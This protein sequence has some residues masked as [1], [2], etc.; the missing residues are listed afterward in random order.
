MAAN[1]RFLSC[2]SRM[3]GLFQTSARFVRRD[4]VYS[5]S[6]NESCS[7]RPSFRAKVLHGERLPRI[8]C[9]QGLGIKS[10]YMGRAAIGKD[11]DHPLGL[12]R[13]GRL[14]HQRQARAQ[15]AGARRGAGRRGGASPWSRCSTRSRSSSPAS[16]WSTWP[17]SGP[18]R[19]G[20]RCRRGRRTCARAARRG[21][22]TT[23][24]P[25]AHT[26]PRPGTASPAS[27]SR[28]WCCCWTPSPTP[29]PRCR[30]RRR[31]Q[32]TCKPRCS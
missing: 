2:P 1:L 21:T 31:W 14:H 6:R 9:Q 29:P 12:G 24:R 7:T 10:V 25:A 5:E 27:A 18:A 23:S 15:V 3:A 13:I 17:R 28:C 8:L 4:L 30:R 22:R 32:S 16:R 20:R 26:S 11:M 19:P